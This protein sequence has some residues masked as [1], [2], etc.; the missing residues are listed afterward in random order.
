[1]RSSFTDA[2]DPGASFLVQYFGASELF[3]QAAFHGTLVAPN[4]TVNLQSIAAGHSGVF[5]T[6]SLEVSPNTG[7]DPAAP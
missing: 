5:L 7:G 4:A 3:V 6:K 2:V 1:M